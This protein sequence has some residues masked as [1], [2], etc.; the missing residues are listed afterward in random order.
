[1]LGEA[2]LDYQYQG[3]DIWYG[4]KTIMTPLVNAKEVRMLPSTVEGGDLSYSFEKGVKIGGGYLDKFKQRTSSRFVNIVE[5]AL[6]DKTEEITGH[7]SGNVLPAYVEWHDAHHAARLYNYYAKDFMNMTYFDAVH[8]HQVNDTLSWTA[9]LQGMHQRGVGHSVGAM[10]ADTAAYGGKIN[11]RFFGLKAGVDYHESSF[12][13][14]YTNVLG[15]R[16]HEHN[17]LVM[18]WDGTPLFTDMITSNDLFTSN[19]GEGLTS[20]GG[21][22]AGTEGIKVAY[23]QKFDFTGLEGFKAVLSYAQY[24][25]SDFAKTQKD[26]N[27]VLAY[28]IGKFD[29]ALKGMWVANNTDAD[30]S[31]KIS[32]YDKL[33][34]YRVIANY[35]F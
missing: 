19:Y 14:A 13:V 12:Q 31:E 25:N 21:Y 2:Y 18:P 32:Q 7:R 28:G 35:K 5:H 24:D 34:Q 10:E 26:K 16:S 22:I 9:A 30:A 6:G 17:S 20:S 3:V 11:A 23:T 33:T 15:F 29:L 27:L 4:R 1:M 8:N